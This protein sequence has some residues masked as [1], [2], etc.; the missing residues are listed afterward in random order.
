M[1]LIQQKVVAYN[2]IREHF[3][4]IKQAVSDSSFNDE[5]ILKNPLRIQLFRHHGYQLESFTNEINFLNLFQKYLVDQTIFTLISTDFEHPDIS[6]SYEKVNIQ[7]KYFEAVNKLRQYIEQTCLE[8][9][10]DALKNY[11]II[12][13]GNIAHLQTI[14]I[15]IEQ[16]FI[17]LFLETLS[18]YRNTIRFQF[19]ELLIIKRPLTIP[20]T[21]SGR[22][23]NETKQIMEEY[24]VERNDRPDAKEKQDLSGQT[25]LTIKQIETWFNNRRSRSL[26]DDT[27][28]K[29]TIGFMNKEIDWDN[30]FFK[31]EKEAGQ[32]IERKEIASC[33][34]TYYDASGIT[35]IDVTPSQLPISS[36]VPF[37]S[38]NGLNLRLNLKKE[39]H[40][41]K[42]AP[43]S[44]SFFSRAEKN[45]ANKN[46]SEIYQSD[47]IKQQ[48][49]IT[50]NNT[51]SKS[52]GCVIETKSLEKSGIDQVQET[53]SILDNSLTWTRE[54]IY[55][56][57]NNSL[58]FVPISNLKVSHHPNKVTAS[59]FA[60][61]YGSS[62]NF[63]RRLVEQTPTYNPEYSEIGSQTTELLISPL[64]YKPPIN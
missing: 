1:E 62:P 26:K 13:F 16:V 40:R 9:K 12:P 25:G 43:Y 47:L 38:K 4:K 14:M 6:E 22:F 42:S 2:H 52:S 32:I 57:F 41:I 53:Y 51:V 60:E 44:K 29:D 45:L 20:H 11:F 48:L 3:L 63:P 37:S 33:D 35:T 18:E 24:F 10:I 64:T 31:I 50:K 34:L 28:D 27:C 23:S 7:A 55:P 61:P 19:S 59:S 58:T 5:T 15:K 56:T 39:A 17:N 21:A 8:R 36:L 49:N 54:K 46:A 30:K